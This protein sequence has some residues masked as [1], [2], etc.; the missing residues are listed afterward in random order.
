VNESHKIKNMHSNGHSPTQP[1]EQTLKTV[2]RYIGILLTVLIITGCS[3]DNEN[4]VVHSDNII[5]DYAGIIHF[6]PDIMEQ[7]QEYNNYLLETFDIDFRVMTTTSEQNINSFTN[8]AYDT[9][10]QQSRSTSGR[11]LLLVIN[12][13][14]D[15]TRIGVSMALEPIYTDVF[16]SY[17]ERKGMVPYFRDS[18]VSDGVYMM[19]ELVKDRALEADQGKEFMS[20]METKTLGGGARNT[21]L[22][23]QIDPGAKQGENI[24]AEEDD[25]PKAILSKHLQALKSHNKKRNLDIY[26]KAT[27]LFFQDRTVTDINQDN[28]YRFIS[29]CYKGEVVF[30]DDN[31]RAVLLHPVK[32]RACTPYYFIREQ[33]KWRLDI[34]TMAK[35][36]RFNTEMHWHFSQKDRGKFNAPYEFVFERFDYDENGYPYTKHVKKKKINR[37]GYTCSDYSLPG[38]P[39]DKIR[40][41]INWL[42]KDGAAK[43]VLGLQVNDVIIG[44][45]DGEDFIENPNLFKSSWYFHTVKPGELATVTVVRNGD[46]SH[47]LQGVA[48]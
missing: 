1:R 24:L 43:N 32:E 6:S 36:L 34:A 14:L 48:P 15:E 42:A 37:W 33:K 46:G 39:P 25:T 12:T 27:R 41:L 10:Q 5:V 21:A 9:F 40:C 38:D 20:P 16:V 28:E 4:A 17:I 19:M 23:G 8:E 3:G 45:G 29:Q 13:N 31:S 22:I 47:M 7:Y 26:S 35:V 11:A 30:S 2:V 44:V 18:R